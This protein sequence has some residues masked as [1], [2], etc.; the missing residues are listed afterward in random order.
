MGWKKLYYWIWL[1]SVELTSILSEYFLFSPQ[2][3]GCGG[4]EL[5]GRPLAGNHVE[6][7]GSKIIGR[8]RNFK[9]WLG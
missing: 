4:L 1:G 8:I 6:N 2:G 7:N 9:G 5:C 3:E